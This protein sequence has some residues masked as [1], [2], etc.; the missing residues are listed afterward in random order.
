MGK[1]GIEPHA[2]KENLVI[3][4]LLEKYHDLLFNKMSVKNVSLFFILR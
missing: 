1:F 2:V 3:E 4:T